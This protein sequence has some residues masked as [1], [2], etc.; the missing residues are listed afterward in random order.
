VLVQLFMP[1]RDLPASRPLLF[2][3]GALL[4]LFVAQQAP[5]AR[6]G[7]GLAGTLGSKGLAGERADEPGPEPD[8]TVLGHYE[9]SSTVIGAYPPP[10]G[11]TLYRAEGFGAW[12]QALE[13]A[14]PSEPVRTYDGRVVPGDFHV[15]KLPLV[16][17]N[18]QQCADTAIRLRAE[19]LREQ[20]REDEILFHATSGDAMPWSRYRGGEKAYEQDNRLSWRRVEPQSWD[21]YLQAVFMWA[22]TM[23]LS[24]DTVQDDFPSAGDVLVLPGAPGH[25]VIIM[26]VANRSGEIFV[27]AG[28]GFMPAQ[29]FHLVRG[30][31]AGWWRWDDGAQIGPWTFPASSLRSWESDTGA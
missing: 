13:L 11:T 31:H 21:Q 8:R 5:V 9:L 27:L 29:S 10:Q 28:Q 16:S 20:G 2:L 14:P 22:G 17:G 19:W 6:A 23:S 24:Y 7:D 4:G 30:P 1:L 25:A 18:L 15:V 3:A 26:A 12:L